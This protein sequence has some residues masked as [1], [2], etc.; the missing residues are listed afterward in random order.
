MRQTSADELLNQAVEISVRGCTLTR[1]PAGWSV[2]DAGQNTLV[3]GKWFDCLEACK[4]GL[5]YESDYFTDAVTAFDAL[6]LA[7]SIP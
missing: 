7:Q 6:V 4:R 5:K 2:R 3:D 1:M